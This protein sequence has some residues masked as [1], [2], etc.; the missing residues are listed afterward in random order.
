MVNACK[1]H[2]VVGCA[3][4][5]FTRICGQICEDLKV[6]EDTFSPTPYNLL[7]HFKAEG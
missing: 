1:C 5:E 3:F 7:L 2:D 6:S 4:I